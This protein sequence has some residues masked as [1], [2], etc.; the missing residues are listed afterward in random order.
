MNATATA[1]GFPPITIV[2]DL[3]PNSIRFTTLLSMR[4]HRAL[5]S[6]TRMA[7]SPAESSS[8]RRIYPCKTYTHN[9]GRMSQDGL[10]LSLTSIP[11]YAILFDFP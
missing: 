9:D 1:D 5:S 10:M 11:H 4:L 2:K 3:S 8:C 6:Y 7:V